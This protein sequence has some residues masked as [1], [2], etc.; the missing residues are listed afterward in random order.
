MLISKKEILKLL[1][2]EDFLDNFVD[3]C[4]NEDG[5]GLDMEGLY[6]CIYDYV[7]SEVQNWEYDRWYNKVKRWVKR[8]GK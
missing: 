7:D 5:R 6:C 2:S 8:R 3:E 1:P 4:D